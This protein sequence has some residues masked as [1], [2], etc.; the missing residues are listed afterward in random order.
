MNVVD[1]RAPVTDGANGVAPAQHQ[2]AGIEAE[3]DVAARQQL[4]DLPWRFDVR[5]S[6]MVEGRVVAP[7]AAEVH[8]LLQV[9]RESIPAFG[10]QSETRVVI[11]P[12]GRQT[13]RGG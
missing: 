12:T 13:A 10:L 3:A 4:F 5:A 6:V 11:G 7:R 1:A 9:R 2:V 8:R